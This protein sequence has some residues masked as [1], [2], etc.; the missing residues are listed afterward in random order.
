MRP[1]TP[2]NGRDATGSA[3]P[4]ETNPPETRYVMF[5]SALRGAARE[6]RSN[7]DEK[8]SRRRTGRRLSRTG[9]GHRRLCPE[10]GGVV[11]RHGGHDRKDREGRRYGG[12][13]GS[14]NASRTRL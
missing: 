14:R 10:Q 2:R 8:G 4:R 11:P 12:S 6:K 3:S 9:S 5:A 1:C 7:N 13:A